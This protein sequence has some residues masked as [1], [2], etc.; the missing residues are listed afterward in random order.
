MIQLDQFKENN[1]SELERAAGDRLVLW[2]GTNTSPTHHQGKQLNLTLKLW[3][4]PSVF[5]Y[6][7]V[8]L[9]VG[10]GIAVVVV[11]H[12]LVFKSCRIGSVEV[13]HSL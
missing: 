6:K 11:L 8:C 13:H 9:S 7:D 1:H 5:D 12:L 10:T 2:F 3:K 4:T